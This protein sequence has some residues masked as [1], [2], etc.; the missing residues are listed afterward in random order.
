VHSGW[1]LSKK[2]QFDVSKAKIHHGHGRRDGVQNQMQNARQS[3]RFQLEKK[4][5]QAC[6][7]LWLP[8][9]LQSLSRNAVNASR[10]SFDLGYVGANLA[11]P[12][13]SSLSSEKPRRSDFPAR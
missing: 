3:S 1:G 7:F 9:M 10:S 8:E 2:R 13:T 6:H 12:K 11:L 5:E 4:N